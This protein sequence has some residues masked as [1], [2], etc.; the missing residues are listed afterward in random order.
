MPHITLLD[1]LQVLAVVIGTMVFI[2]VVRARHRGKAAHDVDYAEQNVC[3]HLRPALELLRSRG[4]RVE[5]V[6]Q[7]GDDFP[8]EIHLG[9][10]FDPQAVYDELKLEPP[11]YVSERNVLYCKEDWC[12]LHPLK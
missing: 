9:P 10:A 11:V 7:L 2:L 12:E 4:H 1:I 5:Q 3:E 6:G 8:L